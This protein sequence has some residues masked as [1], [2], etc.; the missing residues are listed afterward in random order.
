MC[1]ISKSDFFRDCLRGSDV[2]CELLHL[3]VPTHKPTTRAQFDFCQRFWPVHF[4]EDS[5]LEKKL[6]GD[7]FHLERRNKLATLLLEA[8][9]SGSCI[10]AN[11]RSLEVVAT[12]SGSQWSASDPLKHPFMRALDALCQKQRAARKRSASGDSYLCNGKCSIEEFHAHRL[13]R[14]ARA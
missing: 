11:E 2:A 9:S 14:A 10:I 6:N 8:A 4:R 7:F 1:F 3:P 12:A 13:C 5:A